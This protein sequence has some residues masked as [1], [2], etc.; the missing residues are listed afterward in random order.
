MKTLSF[1]ALL[2]AC[3]LFT[4]FALAADATALKGCDAKKANLQTQIDYAKAHNNSHQ[5]AGL[6]KALDEVNAHCTD[7]SLRQEREQKITEA[8]HEVA[9]RQA[10]LAEA[11]KKGDADKI[12][13]RQAKLAESQKELQD[14]MSELDK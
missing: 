6:Q 5:Q 1:V 7:A 9:E 14:A 11:N 4:P 10:D 13:K 8:K 2:A 12:S 3:G